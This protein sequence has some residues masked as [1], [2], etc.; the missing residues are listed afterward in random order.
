M[1]IK[2]ESV[3]AGS[4]GVLPTGDGLMPTD[5]LLL[6]IVISCVFALF[7]A[8]LAWLDHTTTAWVRAK[9]AEKASSPAAQS[10][11]RAA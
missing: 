9:A 10:L 11:Q 1:W 6:S 3:L 8:V 4:L 7:A 5:A 2:A